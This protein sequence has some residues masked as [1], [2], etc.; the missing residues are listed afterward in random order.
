MENKTQKI[1][2]IALIRN[3]EGKILVQKRVD[4]LHLEANGKWE[5]PG[6]IVEF[7]ETLAQAAEREAEEETGCS[8]EIVRLLPYAHMRIWE[9]TDG[10]KVQVFV[11]CFEARLVEGVARP[12]EKES[13]EVRW[14][15]KEEIAALDTLPATN[16]FINLIE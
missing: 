12:L 5:F 8:I 11:S 10:T 4:P 1:V 2:A 7:G 13:S 3:E 6:G 16:E 15:T 14:C 9:R